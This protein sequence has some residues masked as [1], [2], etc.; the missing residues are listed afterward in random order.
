VED[1]WFVQRGGK[2]VGPML[3]AKLKHL[4]ASGK[5]KPTDQVQKQGMNRL[6]TGF[7]QESWISL[8]RAYWRG[9]I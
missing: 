1:Q 4:A 3:T 5:L 6:L 9:S 7:R 2:K 8:L